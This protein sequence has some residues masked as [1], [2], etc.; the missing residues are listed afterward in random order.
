MGI[1]HQKF[2]GTGYFDRVVNCYQRG[3]KFGG[4]AGGVD[5][6]STSSN[7]KEKKAIQYEHRRTQRSS[8]RGSPGG[9]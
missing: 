9:R 8:P 3:R 6:E 5:G 1:T 2:V 4:G 7:P